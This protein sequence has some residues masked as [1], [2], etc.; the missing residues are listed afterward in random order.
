VNVPP[1]FDDAAFPIRFT[2]NDPSSHAELHAALRIALGLADHVEPKYT[3][4][5]AAEHTRLQ[6]PPY[7]GFARLEGVTGKNVDGN[8]VALVSYAFYYRLRGALMYWSSSLDPSLPGGGGKPDR[9]WFK[10]G[11]APVLLTP[12]LRARAK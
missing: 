11:D 9:L 5:K 4:L 8:K 6:T 7:D 2:V 1:S 12:A 3:S 10:D